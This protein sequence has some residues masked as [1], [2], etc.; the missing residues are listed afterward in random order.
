[1]ITLLYQARGSPTGGGLGS[2]LFRDVPLDRSRWANLPIGW[3]F[4]HGIT[5]GIGDGVFGF[6]TTLSREEMVLFLCRAVE[7]YTLTGAGRFPAEG[8]YQEPEAAPFLF[9]RC[10]VSNDRNDALGVATDWRI[11]SSADDGEVI[12]EIGVRGTRTWID[13]RW[14]S[15]QQP[16]S[17]V[18]AYTTTE[19]VTHLQDAGSGTLHLSIGEPLDSPFYLSFEI[20]GVRAVLNDLDCW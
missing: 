7:G 8:T 13:E 20:E 18:W 16:N 19:L 11:Y 17:T 3:A 10:G 2:Y 4:E 5:G 6:G 15:D 12:A 9:L 14:Y 1:M